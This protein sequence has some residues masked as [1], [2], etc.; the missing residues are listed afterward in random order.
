MRD[1][2]SVGGGN[3]GESLTFRRVRD[4]VE[5]CAAIHRS[6]G[7]TLQSRS[8]QSTAEK[9]RVLLE[10]LG[11]AERALADEVVAACRRVDVQQ[12]DR[13]DV[14]AWLQ[15]TPSSLVEEAKRRSES[16]RSIERTELDHEA[17]AASRALTRFFAELQVTAPTPRQNE[18]LEGLRRI[19]ARVDRRHSTTV[20]ASLV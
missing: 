6:M 2:R 13:R 11:E 5:H 20:D 1:E 18:L 3:R 10:T 17:R 16:L 12:P 9:E 15:S 14:E 4:L 7:E 19:E 8:E